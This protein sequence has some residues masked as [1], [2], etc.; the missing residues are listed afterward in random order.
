[1]GELRSKENGEEEQV[2]MVS[3]ADGVVGIQEEHMRCL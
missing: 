3:G 1:M 2:H